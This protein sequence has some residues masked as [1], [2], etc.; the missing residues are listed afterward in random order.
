M[1]APQTLTFLELPRSFR[2]IR[3][4]GITHEFIDLIKQAYYGA[5]V[6]LAHVVKFIFKWVIMSTV[7]F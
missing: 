4:N 3:A 2:A 1:F 6:F 5:N 7:N